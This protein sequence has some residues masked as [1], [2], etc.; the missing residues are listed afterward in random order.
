MAITSS[1]LVEQKATAQY[2]G[3]CG[4]CVKV[5][6]GVWGWGL[7]FWGLSVSVLL[8]AMTLQ[9]VVSRSR[10][11]SCGKWGGVVLVEEG[12]GHWGHLS[13]VLRSG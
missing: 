3:Q 2:V 9:A 5:T 7:G 13:L 6:P 12:R 11:S 1:L 10:I 4:H 8:S